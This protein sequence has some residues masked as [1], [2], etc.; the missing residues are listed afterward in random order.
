ME[1]LDGLAN[2]TAEENPKYLGEWPHWIGSFVLNCASIELI[3]YKY[4]DYLELTRKDFDKNIGKPLSKRIDR[5]VELISASNLV[6]NESKEEL[7]DLWDE[8]RDCSKWRNRV[9]HNPLL[10]TWK[11]GSDSKNSPPDVLGIPDM[12]QVKGS[13]TSNSISLENLKK[14]VDLSSDLAKRL[15]ISADELKINY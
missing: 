9:A 13:N 2:L 8:V 4:L 15:L 3:S 11:P 7:A 10:P 6:S 1:H 12:K 5:I 14:L